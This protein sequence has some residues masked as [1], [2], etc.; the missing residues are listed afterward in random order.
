MHCF[1]KKF[2]T[3]I[4]TR[5]EW[6]PGPRMS[7]GMVWYTN[8]LKT[9][10][11]VREGVYDPKIGTNLV[12]PMDSFPALVQLL[13]RMTIIYCAEEIRKRKITNKRMT[14]YPDSQAAIKAL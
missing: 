4:P 13:I 2:N 10:L 11:G 6:V 14:T 1:N 8:C 7:T 5:G 3:N 9:V 12:I